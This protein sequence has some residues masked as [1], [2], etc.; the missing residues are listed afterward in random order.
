MADGIH[1]TLFPSNLYIDINNRVV[2]IIGSG[3]TCIIDVTRNNKV[4]FL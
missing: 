3:K 4:C 1:I 2:P